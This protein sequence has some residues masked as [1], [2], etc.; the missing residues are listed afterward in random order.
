MIKNRIAIN[1][2]KR[3]GKDELGMILQYLTSQ[4]GLH[5]TRTYLE[6]RGKTDNMGYGYA[7]FNRYSSPWE[8]HKFA[9][10]GDEAFKLLFGYDWRVNKEKN[11]QTYINF[12]EGIKERHGKDV[13]ANALVRELEEVENAIITDLRFK[14]ELEA[15]KGENTLL[16][17]IVRPELVTNDEKHY[18]ERD[19][20][21]FD[22][23]NY[24]IYN[25]GTLNELV[26]KVREILIKENL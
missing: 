9:T 16:I 6:A 4:H 22:G 3:H 17:K 19:L 8:I 7:D 20:N 26:E 18:G 15:I 12:V 13:F 14:E 11:R 25:E 5:G 23:W 2:E 10:A 21:D 1:G 24:I